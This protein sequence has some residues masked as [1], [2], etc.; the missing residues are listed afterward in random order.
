MELYLKDTLTMK[1]FEEFVNTEQ[2]RRATPDAGLARALRK[3]AEM[4]VQVILQLSLSAESATLVFEQVYEAL[5]QCIDALLALNGYKSY[6]HIASI[7]F[8]QRFPEF[9]EADIN[10]L[11]NARE[12]R[13]LAKYYAK[14]VLPEETKELLALYNK[15]KPKL[16]TVFNQIAK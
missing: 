3:D 7:V 1:S 12:K 15:L 8:L 13:N 2:V 16:D 10:N 9:T 11:D 5:R 6:S 4:R 14:Q